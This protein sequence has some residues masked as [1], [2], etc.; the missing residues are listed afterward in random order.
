MRRSFLRY[1]LLIVAAQLVRLALA[2]APSDE[3]FQRWQTHRQSVLREAGLVRYYTFELADATTAPNLQGSAGALIYKPAKGGPEQPEVVT[4]RWP[5]KKAL[6]IDRGALETPAFP[7]QR[8]FSFAGWFRLNGQGG[9]RGNNEAT[10]GT[11]IAAGNGYNEGWRLTIEH[12]AQ[13]MAVSIGQPTPPHANSVATPAV[14]RGVWQHLAVTW[15]GQLLRAYAGGLLV[16][17]RTYAGPYTPTKNL[18]I[19]WTGNGVGSVIMDLDELACYDRALAPREIL[20]AAHGD[21]PLPAA[22][23]ALFDAA[24]QATVAKDYQTAAGQWAKLAALESLDNSYRAAAGLQLSRV[25]LLEHRPAEA[26]AALVRLYGAGAT[27]RDIEELAAETLIRLLPQL[28]SATA[29]PAIYRQLLARHGTSPDE[30]F[31]LQLALAQ[32][33]LASDPAAARG[34]FQTLLAAPGLTD[35]RRIEL[36]M[37]LGHSCAAAK[38]DAAATQAYQA[39]LQ[40]PGLPPWQQAIALFCL[41]DVQLRRGDLSAARR[42]LAQVVQIPGI[43]PHLIDEAQQ[44][45]SALDGKQAGPSHAAINWP[46]PAVQLYVGPSG[47]DDNPGTLE[48]PLATLERARDLLRERKAK[49]PLPPGGAAVVL[50]G[51]AYRV[52]QTFKLG[53]E[54]SGTAAAPIVYLAYPGEAVRLTAGQAVHNFVP[55][56]DPAILQRLPVE[57]RSRVRQADLRAQGIKEFGPFK[58][59]GYASGAGFGTR[60]LLEVFC[61]GRALTIARWPNAGYVEVGKL[62]D[63]ASAFDH[64]G[65]PGTK[66]GKFTYEGDRPARWLAESDAWLYG[67]WFHDWADSY[68]K[69]AAI[70]P[71]AHAITL[72]PPFHRYGYRTKQRY[73]ALNLLAEIDEPGEWYLDRASGILYVDPPTDLNRATVEVSLLDGPLVQMD[74]VSHVMFRGLTWELGRGDGVVV[75][76]SEACVFAGCTIRKCGGDGLKLAGQDHRVLSCDLYQLGRGGIALLGGDR[77]RLTSGRHLVENCRIHDISQID[78]T[79]TPAIHLSGV[80]HCVRHNELHHGN[81]SALRIEGN[82]HLVEFNDVH[83]VLMESDDQGGIDMFGNPGYRGNIYRYNYWHDIGNGLG[84]GQAGIRLDDA[85][86]GTVIYGN[87]FARCSDGNF[88]GVQIHGGKDNIV[89]NNLFVDCKSA[90]SFSP[91][92]EARWNEY[93]DRPEVQKMLNQ[94]VSIGAP[95]YSTRYPELATLRQQPNVNRVWRNVALNCG[96]LLFRDRGIQQ[97]VDNAVLGV[98]LPPG[99]PNGR[100]QLPADV[101]ALRRPGFRPIPWD[102]IGTYRDDLRPSDKR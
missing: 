13:T 100:F 102:Q 27:P 78:H 101:P 75:K 83:H 51:G 66:V 57:S 71:A 77:K 56:S 46:Q 23:A 80:G 49:Q 25:L 53:Q 99:D 40:T 89:D 42:C 52:T 17:Q 90:I 59:A 4:G 37:E 8:A 20:Q 18:R 87:V 22:A 45:T 94:A 34:E 6:R 32:R 10:N 41:A 79:Y 93:L 47:R 62:L 7:I 43:A 82:D 50:R 54:D 12:P 9:M 1:V 86:C 84:V 2:A 58:L 72:A 44:R 88:G 29:A 3:A 68:E 69:V 14:P 36:Q 61:D 85:I 5:Q 38:D 63:T 95:P 70:D 26:V 73:Y 11:L 31:N 65:V 48:R 81:S 91:W 33:L 67:Y 96:Q 39:V 15:D 76:D 19:G 55:V 21:A 16:A 24:T 97:T 74:K 35:V 60:P 92:P 98:E 28:Q 64:R 30:R